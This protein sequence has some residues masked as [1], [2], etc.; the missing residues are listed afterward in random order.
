MPLMAS[1]FGDAGR[2]T[3]FVGRPAE[4]SSLL[5]QAEPVRGGHPWV[6]LPTGERGIGKMALAR[7]FIAV[8]AVCRIPGGRPGGGGEPA[9]GHSHSSD[10]AAVPAPVVPAQAPGGLEM[11]IMRSNQNG[12]RS[13]DQ[14]LIV[15]GAVLNSR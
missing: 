3:Q 10:Q 11:S 7:Q 5:A 14:R 12:L 8:A 1:R 9:H 4:M 6:V 13:S 2:T 15:V